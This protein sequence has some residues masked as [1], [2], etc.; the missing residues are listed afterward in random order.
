MD[1]LVF[2]LPVKMGGKKTRNLTPLPG[3]RVAKRRVRRSQI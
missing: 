1:G 2:P 3:E